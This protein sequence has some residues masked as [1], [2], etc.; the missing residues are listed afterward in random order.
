[1]YWVCPPLAG[2]L[3]GE[4]HAADGGD[5]GRGVVQP[6]P[7]QGHGR[8]HPDGRGGD[9][10]SAGRPDHQ[11]PDDEELA[12]H[13]ALRGGHQGTFSLVIDTL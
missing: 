10:D 8:V 6:L 13:Q 4:V 9:P 2:V 5:V 3:P 12:L 11:D 7:L 1:M